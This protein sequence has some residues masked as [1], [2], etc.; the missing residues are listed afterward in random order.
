MLS[1]IVYKLVKALEYESINGEEH[2]PLDILP[3][4]IKSRKPSSVV[5]IASTHSGFESIRAPTI[6]PP[7]PKPFVGEPFIQSPPA[8]TILKTETISVDK[9]PS[10]IQDS[11]APRKEKL[12]KL[13]ECFAD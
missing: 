2:D 1:V 6:T 9:S 3:T 10:A 12:E 7:S 5:A 8:N 4:V 11:E 13:P